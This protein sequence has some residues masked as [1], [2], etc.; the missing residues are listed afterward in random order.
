[1]ELHCDVPKFLDADFPSSFSTMNH[2]NQQHQHNDPESHI[3]LSVI[4]VDADT[5][6]HNRKLWLQRLTKMFGPEIGERYTNAFTQHVIPAENPPNEMT[7]DQF[8]E[9]GIPIGHRRPILELMEKVR[10]AYAFRGG[11]EGNDPDSEHSS[12]NKDGTLTGQFDSAPTPHDAKPQFLLTQTKLVSSSGL[13]WTDFEGSLSSYEGFIEFVEKHLLKRG[14][15]QRLSTEFLQAFWDNKPMPYFVRTKTSSSSSRSTS[16]STKSTL[17]TLGSNIS[18]HS[19][20]GSP[21][22]NKLDVALLLLRVPSTDFV[23]D[24]IAVKECETHSLTNRFVI[25]YQPKGPEGGVIRTY[26]KEPTDSI[27]WLQ[28]IKAGWDSKRFSA[29]SRKKLLTLLV[30]EIIQ[31][32][33]E[34]LDALRA[35]LETLIDI[36]VGFS[37][38]LVVEW[39]SCVN[40]Q[41]QVMKRCAIANATA[42]EQFVKSFELE[43]QSTLVLS[44]TIATNAQDVESNAMDA[45][46]LRMGLVGFR[47]Q[48]NM[49]FFTYVSA[50]TAPMAVLTGWYG[51]NFESMPEVKTQDGYWWFIAAAVT[52]ISGTMWLIQ[53]FHR[54]TTSTTAQAKLNAVLRGS[55]K[56]RVKYWCGG[57]GPV[58]LEGSYEPQQPPSIQLPP[59]VGGSNDNWPVQDVQGSSG[60]SLG[61]VSEE[62]MTAAEELLRRTVSNV[63]GK[64]ASLA[65][66]GIRKLSGGT[67]GSSVPISAQGAG[68]RSSVR[69]LSPPG[70]PANEIMSPR[71]RIPGNF[72][73]DAWNENDEHAQE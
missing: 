24:P 62:E 56:Q 41:A 11:V 5:L 13:T 8:R 6:T 16:N 26:H 7:D 48:E 27:P 46:N 44:Q 35:Q 20:S 40:R 3:H 4:A 59:L 47:S 34:V 70:R 37:P 69:L 38:T 54:E 58:T 17:G 50:V 23:L 29:F 65:L 1:M 53:Y 28:E 49:K 2:N 36:R 72:V 31:S 19:N 51:M 18:A 68:R 39:M 30:T 33:S 15:D 57:D 42:T 60:V 61:L 73:V 45:M 66:P 71:G 63:R 22:S 9:M 25:I 67:G 32:S 64:R 12:L 52:V 14:T 10:N 21:S 55:V 43:A